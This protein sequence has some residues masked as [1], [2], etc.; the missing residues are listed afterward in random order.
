MV[1]KMLALIRPSLPEACGWRRIRCRRVRMKWASPARGKAAK[2]LKPTALALFINFLLIPLIAWTAG[3]L[4]LSQYP[5]IW[6]GAILYTLTPCIGWYLIFTDLAKGN[7]AWGI[8]LLPWNV[9]LQV[10]LLPAYLYLLVGKVL[11][12]DFGP[13]VFSVG[14]YLVAPFVL[15]AFLRRVIISAQGFDY[16][17]GPFKR[18]LGE[19]KLWALVIVIVS[20]F[21]SQQPLGLPIC[22]RS[23]C[24][25]F[26][27]SVSF[28]ASFLL[29]CSRVGCSA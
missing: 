12:V 20:M 4:I 6:V 2:R 18:A 10:L 29:R 11:P 15:S 14:L 26:S 23:A 8:A 25:F 19:I 3:W 27:L 16:F 22:R 9:T 5:D 1:G 24:S 21:V 17:S 7:V 13:L 28:S